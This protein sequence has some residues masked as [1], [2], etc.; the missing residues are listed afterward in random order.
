MPS[1]H[2]HRRSKVHSEIERGGKRDMGRGGVVQR[3]VEPLRADEERRMRAQRH[4]R[5]EIQ[6]DRKMPLLLHGRLKSMSPEM[7]M[8]VLRKEKEKQRIYSIVGNN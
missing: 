2:E 4:K 6:S 8:Q 7:I 1:L 5:R 3:L